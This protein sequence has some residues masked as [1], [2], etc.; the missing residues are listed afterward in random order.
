VAGQ[1]RTPCQLIALG[2]SGA[3]IAGH[4]PAEAGASV[5]LE[6][7]DV[8]RLPALVTRQAETS[9]EVQ[10]AAADDVRVELTQKLFSGR[11]RT[12]PERT[13]FSDVLKAVALRFVSI[14]SGR[15]SRWA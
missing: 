11:Y 7:D 3:K 4:A 14:G 6:L 5:L 8:G 10:F 2:L 13:D 12:T 1:N 15:L 9:F